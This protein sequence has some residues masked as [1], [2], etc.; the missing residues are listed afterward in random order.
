MRDS[1][2]TFKRQVAALRREWAKSYRDEPVRAL[3]ILTELVREAIRMNA[4]HGFGLT[5]QPFSELGGRA[6]DRSL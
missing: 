6:T 2:A 4:D 3:E 1:E 5:D